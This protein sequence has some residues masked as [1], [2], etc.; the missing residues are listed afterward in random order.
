MA[1]RGI[2]KTLVRNWLGTGADDP[3]FGDTAAGV[4]PLL[5]PAVQQVVDDLIDQIHLA[6]PQYLS[7]F[8]ALVADDPAGNLYSLANQA[9]PIID[10]SHWLELRMT[11]AN[12]SAFEEARLE[13][14]QSVGSGYFCITGPDETPVVQTSPDTQSGVGLWLRYGY[15]PTDLVDDNTVIPGIPL[16]FHDVVAL[17]TL[18]VFGVGGESR[19]PEELRERR[20]NRHASLIA[21]VTKRGV[22]QGRTRLD[23]HAGSYLG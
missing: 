13:E 8:S 22:Q 5:D 18:F 17:E 6:S 10:F 19:W 20:Q 7:K 15:W 11:D 4:S 12:G 14:L 1:T 3:V 9:V 2:I 16:R 21:H 23:Q